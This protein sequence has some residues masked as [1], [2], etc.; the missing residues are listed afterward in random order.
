M[1]VAAEMSAITEQFYLKLGGNLD[2]E[3]D[4][5]IQSIRI[6]ASKGNKSFSISY[7][8]FS[9]VGGSESEDFILKNVIRRLKKDGFTVTEQE[10]SHNSSSYFLIRWSE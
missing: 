6:S 7:N 9:H 3:Y 1:S 5:I 4:K 2:Q 8:N 10:G